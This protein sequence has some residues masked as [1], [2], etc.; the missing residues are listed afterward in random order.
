[1]FSIDQNKASQGNS[2]INYQERAAFSRRTKIFTSIQK[3]EIFIA[4]VYLKYF[5][6]ERLCK[7]S[8]KKKVLSVGWIWVTTISQGATLK[9]EAETVSRSSC[10]SSGI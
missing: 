5:K 6:C 4:S 2:R 1:M 9:W 3:L 8:A 10:N 7:V